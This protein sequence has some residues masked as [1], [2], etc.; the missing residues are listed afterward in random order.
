M[1]QSAAERLLPVTDVSPSPNSA[2]HEMKNSHKLYAAVGGSLLVLA[3]ILVVVSPHC[4][5]TRVFSSW[6][7]SIPGY[8]LNQ[9]VQFQ[10]HSHTVLNGLHT[11]L[12]SFLSS[13]AKLEQLIAMPE[14]QSLT[15]EQCL[16]QAGN[17]A[18]EKLANALIIITGGTGMAPVR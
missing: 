1:V 6:T 8:A 18:E 15:A 7:Q 16:Q 3:L 10:P 4:A 12:S 17:G 14:D 5:M 13:P 9:P 11:D 2:K